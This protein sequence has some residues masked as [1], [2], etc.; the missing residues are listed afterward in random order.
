MPVVAEIQAAIRASPVVH[1]DETGLRENG[2]NGYVW[3]FST[4]DQRYFVRGSRAK[5]ML[6]TAL[7]NE[8]A[9]VLVSDFYGVYTSYEGLHQYC[10]AHLLRDIHDLTAEHPHDAAVRGWAAAIHALFTRAQAVTEP[11]PQLRRRARHALERELR[12]LCQP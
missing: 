7:G 10:W 1:A 12:A 8:F 9:G 5:T 4:P 11:E 2:H 6:E 3:T